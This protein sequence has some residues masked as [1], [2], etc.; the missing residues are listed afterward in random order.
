MKST[1]RYLVG[2]VLVLTLDAGARPGSTPPKLRALIIGI[3]NYRETNSWPALPGCQKDVETV[4]Q[5]LTGPQVA[6]DAAHLR[7]LAEK[8]ATRAGIE[9]AFQQLVSQAQPGETVYIHYS[10]HGGLVESETLNEPD[11]LDECLVPIDAP[12]FKTAAYATKVVRDKF[13]V[14]ILDQLVNKVRANGAEGSVLLVFDSCHSGGLSRG[15]G[16]IRVRQGTGL[17]KY[18]STKLK[19]AF[20]GGQQ[21]AA[22]SFGPTQANASPQAWVVLSACEYYQT[23]QDT[24]QGGSF[25]LALLGALQDPRLPGNASYAD[26]MQL[27]TT[28]E[29]VRNQSPQSAG[30]RNLRIFGGSLKNHQPWIGVLNQSG[31]LISL[32]K[33]SLLGVTPGTQIGIYPVGSS[34][35]EGP[36]LAT[37]LVQEPANP[38][39]SKARLEGKA[40]AASLQGC[41]AWVTRPGAGFRPITLSLQAGQPQIQALKE[42]LASD[43]QGQIEVVPR[44]GDL[45]VRAT[46]SNT[47]S[48]ERTGNNETPLFQTALSTPNLT[49]AFKTALTQELRSRHF[50]QIPDSA[51]QNIQVTLTRGQQVGDNVVPDTKPSADLI[52]KPGEAAEL[53]IKNSSSQGRYISVFYVGSNGQLQVFYPDNDDMANWKAITNQSPP[54][55]LPLVFSGPGGLDCIRV[56]ATREKID[57]PYLVGGGSRGGRRTASLQAPPSDLE[58]FLDSSLWGR[59]REMQRL[60]PR[61]SDFEISPPLMIQI[62]P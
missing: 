6:L 28:S 41:V 59:G 54:I 34:A 16:Q 17:M 27:I 56:L 7:V 5:F 26:L 18:F 15:N 51:T 19:R 62:R 3:S 2:A 1:L 40:P 4:Q 35:P 48:L 50:L 29:L 42:T 8:E 10:G 20:R 37:A 47:L 60:R 52:F 44:G 55:K 43:F 21:A 32:D 23:A 49:A 45:T 39:Q 25:T 53:S 33:G 61:L 14:S 12:D 46:D 24:D 9:G 31:G 38:F 13:V 36:P 22:P 57:L 11:G 30:E 58:A